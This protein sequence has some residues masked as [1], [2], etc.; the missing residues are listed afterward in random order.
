VPDGA[1]EALRQLPAVDSATVPAGKGDQA[2]GDEIAR[3]DAQDEGTNI[4]VLSR[5]SGAVI[6]DVVGVLG[7]AGA[8]IIGVDVREPNLESVFLHLTGKSLRD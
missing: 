5:D 7:R 1:L 2:E 8:R 4:Q 3:D 6:A